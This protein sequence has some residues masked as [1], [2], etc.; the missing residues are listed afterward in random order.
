V[1]LVLAN[2]LNP[3][4]F[5]ADLEVA[6]SESLQIDRRFPRPVKT[7]QPLLE[8]Q[9]GGILAIENFR[10]TVMVDREVV[11]RLDAEGLSVKSPLR[12]QIFNN[13]Q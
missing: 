3:L 8:L 7:V 1:Y 2:A 4:K 5:S 6:A 12:C 13:L 10:D 9:S 11:G